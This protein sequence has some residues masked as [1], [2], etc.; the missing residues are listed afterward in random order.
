MQGL[1]TMTKT[2][3]ILPLIYIPV[4]E[5]IRYD[6]ILHMHEHY[7]TYDQYIQCVNM[8]G[9]KHNNRAACAWL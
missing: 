1:F 3:R 6:V 7:S 2:I 5:Y 9:G 8:Y 4:A